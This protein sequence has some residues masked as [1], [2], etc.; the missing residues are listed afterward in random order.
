MHFN[1]DYTALLIFFMFNFDCELGGGALRCRSAIKRILGT[2]HTLTVAVFSFLLNVS[3][4][5]MF[6][7]ILDSASRGILEPRFSN[8]PYSD[9][10][11][12]GFPNPGLIS[13]I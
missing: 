10:W 6:L 13:E 9:P 3:S 4:K 8:F 5:N 1:S 11:L 7:G 2:S 12:V